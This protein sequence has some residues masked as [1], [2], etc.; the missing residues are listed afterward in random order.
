VHNAPA[1]LPVVVWGQQFFDDLV[2]VALEQAHDKNWTEHKSHPDYD[3]W[4]IQSGSVRVT[5][6]ESEHTAG[7]GDAVFFYPDMQTCTVP[8]G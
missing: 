3:L 8:F 4:F 6:S 5:I 7:P 1:R 2:G